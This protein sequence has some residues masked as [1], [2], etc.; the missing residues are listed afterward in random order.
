MN[1]ELIILDVSSGQI[2]NSSNT[3]QNGILSVQFDPLK[4]FMLRTSGMD[5][6]L[7]FWDIRKLSTPVFGIFNNSHW[8]W[9]AKYNHTYSNII[10]TC[11]SS[12]LV[13]GFIFDK[14]EDNNYTFNHSCVDFLEFEDAVYDLDWDGADPWTFGAISYNSYLHIN[15]IPADIKYKIMLDH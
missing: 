9:N 14:E 6:S 1:S 15:N 2:I 11:S 5:Y 4:S 7:K 12:S 8:I 13:R 3:N 10:L